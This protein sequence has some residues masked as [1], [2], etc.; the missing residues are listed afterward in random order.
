MGRA[1]RGHAAHEMTAW[2]GQH[3]GMVPKRRGHGAGKVWACGGG[4]ET[5]FGCNRARRE[6]AIRIFFFSMWDRFGIK[7]PL[8]LPK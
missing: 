8:R 6:A 4:V 3:G 7:L 5:G 1:T 2:D